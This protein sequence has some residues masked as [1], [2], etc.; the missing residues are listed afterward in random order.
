MK[1]GKEGEGVGQGGGRLKNNNTCRERK[2]EEGRGETCRVRA[3]MLRHHQQQRNRTWPLIPGSGTRVNRRRRSAEVEWRRKRIWSTRRERKPWP[4]RSGH[5]S[6]SGHPLMTL[7]TLE[8]SATQDQNS[9]PGTTHT[10]IFHSPR[11]TPQ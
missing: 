3:R 7:H 10:H 11:K 8:H 9:T 4:P 6:G 5:G 2:G 1:A